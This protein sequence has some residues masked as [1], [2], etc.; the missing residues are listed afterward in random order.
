MGFTP[1]DGRPDDAYFVKYLL[2]VHRDR[3]SDSAR[4]T[5]Q[6]NLSLEKLLAHR[7]RIP[8]PVTRSRVVRILRSF[9]DLIENSQ[10]RVNALVEMA[11]AIHREWFVHF[12]Y[13]GHEE[14]SLVDSPD[15]PFTYPLGCRGC[16]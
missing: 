16:G 14:V 9:D 8:G 13:P 15:G 5:T 2:D 11:R 4:G 10:R 6:D 12:R 3:L 7:F 1:A